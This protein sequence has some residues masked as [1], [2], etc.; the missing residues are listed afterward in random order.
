LT[1]TPTVKL[2]SEQIET[3]STSK[4]VEVRAVPFHVQFPV[5]A[6]L[7]TCT[8]IALLYFDIAP[9]AT[10]LVCVFALV[11]WA[12]T[13]KDALDVDAIS[14]QE[15]IQVCMLLTDG[16]EVTDIVLSENTR[17]YEVHTRKAPTPYLVPETLIRQTSDPY[18]YILNL[19]WVKMS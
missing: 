9:I 13:I 15:I 5:L 4:E 1:L 12:C 2:S 18:K 19:D 17:Y 16:S 3:I 14:H 8:S 7:S 6:L 10:P 11:M